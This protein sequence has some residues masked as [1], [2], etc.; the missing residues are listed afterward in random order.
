MLGGGGR[1]GFKGLEHMSGMFDAQH[2]KVPRAPLG[3]PRTTDLGIKLPACKVSQI[4][5][6]VVVQCLPKH[7]GALPPS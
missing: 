7:S 2:H 5:P 6:G 3:G 4:P 1:G